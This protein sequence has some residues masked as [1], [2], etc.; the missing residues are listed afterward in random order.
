MPEPSPTNLLEEVR[1]W[2]HNRSVYP[3]WL[4]APNSVRHRLWNRTREWLLHFLQVRSLL[5]EQQLLEALFELNWR[6]ET[7]LVPILDELIPACEEALAKINPFPQ[8]VTDLSTATIVF[9]GTAS[10]RV[11]W[12]S[13]RRQWISVAFG[14]TRYYREAFNSESFQRWH[15][16]L[17]RIRDLD[18]EARAKLVYERCLFA[19]GE[20]E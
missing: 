15:A 19:F 10:P 5:N 3:G 9:S 20:I 6:L 18:I 13:I 2:T 12:P 14:L 17:S 7:S 16:R 4:I 1:T 11:N 8:D